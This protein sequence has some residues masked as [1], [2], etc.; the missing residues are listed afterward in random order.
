MAV[1]LDDII[2]L[3]NNSTSKNLFSNLSKKINYSKEYYNDCLNIKLP[4]I[5]T[6][7]NHIYVG[8]MSDSITSFIGSSIV[9]G[10]IVALNE[11]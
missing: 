8:T 11:Y 10:E 4:H 7:P 6:D 5:I 3:S 1:D 9:S 2:Y